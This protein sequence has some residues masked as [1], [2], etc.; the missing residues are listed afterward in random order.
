LDLL[1]SPR[2]FHEFLLPRYRRI[3]KTVRRYG[4]RVFMHC[5]GAIRQ[6][7]PD[8]IDAGVEILNPVQTRARG[9]AAD[10]LKR[11]FGEK[12]TFCGGMDVQST[13]PFGTPEDVAQEVRDRIAI[14][15]KGGGYIL[16]STNFIQADTTAE[17]VLAMFDTGRSVVPS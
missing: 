9:M 5:C 4:I 17:N 6:A 1:I 15:G 16:D 14:L 2:M 13:L 7:I 10:G 11:D 12:L 3:F 8:L